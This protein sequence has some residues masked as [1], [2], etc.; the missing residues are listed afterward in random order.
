M[1]QGD[2]ELGLYLKKFLDGM[3]IESVPYYRHVNP[4]LLKGISLMEKFGSN[5]QG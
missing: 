2:T 3:G 1:L 4:W 5:P